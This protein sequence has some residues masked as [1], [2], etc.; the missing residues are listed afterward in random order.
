MAGPMCRRS[1][2]Q[3][4]VTVVSRLKRAAIRT[5]RGSPLRRT[6]SS[7][8][9]AC[10]SSVTMRSALASAD[11]APGQSITYFTATESKPVASKTFGVASQHLTDR[12]CFAHSSIFR[13]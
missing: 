7:P 1:A 13:K 11:S 4:K 3:A 8:S 5:F 9:N 6:F 10:R 12:F 2:I